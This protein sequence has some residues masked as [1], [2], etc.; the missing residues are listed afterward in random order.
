MHLSMQE[1]FAV[2]IAATLAVST[3]IL[4]YSNIIGWTDLSNALTGV[5]LSGI[6]GAIVWGFKTR[7]FMGSVHNTAFQ[8]IRK[9]YRERHRTKVRSGEHRS[10]KYELAKGESIVGTLSSDGYFN[11]YFLTESSFRSYVSGGRFKAVR[12]REEVTYVEPNF[13]APRTGIY[14]VVLRNSDTKDI[15]LDVNLSILPKKSM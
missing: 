2:V 1:A 13:D 8:H 11:V 4:L 14:F 3:L 9:S 15:S 5:M 6:I 7:I 10:F 12:M